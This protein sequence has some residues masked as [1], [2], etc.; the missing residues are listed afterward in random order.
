[1]GLIAR[2]YIAA[3]VQILVHMTRLSTGERKVTRISEVYGCQDGVYLLEDVFV[4]R[5][6]GKDASGRAQGSFYA[7]GYEPAAL[8]RLDARGFETRKDLFIAREL[9][10]DDDYSAE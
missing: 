4:Y 10:N 3:A 8:D 2:Q 9:T 5:T 7:T 6:T 1:M